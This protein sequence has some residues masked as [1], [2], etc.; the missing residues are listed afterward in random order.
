MKHAGRHTVSVDEYVAAVVGA[1]PEL[2]VE[3]VERLRQ[4]LAPPG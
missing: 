1:A 3:Q 2:S 4:A